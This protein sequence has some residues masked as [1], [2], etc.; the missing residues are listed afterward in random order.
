MTA[1][2]PGADG[3]VKVY[4]YEREKAGETPVVQAALDTLEERGAVVVDD[5]ADADVAIAP[6]L[7][8]K[9]PAERL[10]APAL[11]TLIFHPSLLPRHRG[12]DA[13]RWAFRLN[14]TYTGTTWFWAD[15]ELDAGDICESEVLAI[16]EGERPR[17]FYARAVVPSAARTLAHIITDLTSGHVRRRPQDHA[18][19]TYE[20]PIPRS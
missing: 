12:R 5:P 3:R 15:E 7:T 4:V 1:W 6:L 10:S 20:P 18:S 8:K 14:E 17:E 11:G 2:R 9:L 13:I 16:R 19:A